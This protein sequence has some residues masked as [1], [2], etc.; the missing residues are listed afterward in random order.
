MSDIWRLIRLTAPRKGWM[1]AGLGLATLT[2]LAN[3]G[4]LALSGWFLAATAA[5]GLAGYAAQNAF[6]FF[7]PSAMV[8]FFATLRV[9]SRY[10]ERLVTH[11]ATFRLLADLRVW[12]YTRLEPLAPAALQGQRSADLLGRIVSDIDTLNLFYL[13]VF[14][15]VLTALAAALLMASFF[16]FFSVPAAL[17]LILGLG[18]NGALAPVLTARL[19]A[20]PG[21]AITRL[22]SGLR[23]EY[24]EALQ[25][26]GE[27]LVS[28]AAPAMQA[29][30]AA[31][32]EEL[33]A[34]QARLGG[35]AALGASLSGLA[36]NATLLAVLVFG[37]RRFEAGG[38]GAAQV[39]M[40]LL[41]A[42]AAF[43]ATA[44]L[45]GALNYLG[46]IKTAARRIFALADQMPPISP[47]ATAAP[48]LQRYDLEL[49]GVDLAYDGGRKVL[50]GFS[51]SLPQGRHVGIVGVSGSGKSTLINLLLR[52]HEYQAGTARLGGVDLRAFSSAQMARH[53]TIISQR[54]H[55]FH[56]SIRDNLLLANGA[57]DEAALWHA[58]EVAQLA[59]FVRG[60]AQG[61]DHLVGEGGASLSGGQ[62]R[63]IA[64]ARAVLKPAPLLIL[65][66]PTEGLDVETERAFLADLAPLLAGRSVLYITHR[67]AGLA[68]MDEVY[69]LRDGKA[70]RQR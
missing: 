26:M 19:G 61:L 15:P 35:V 28:G 64:L 37:A 14:V 30:A 58:L 5:A 65:D 53:A 55:L 20:G 43:E 32:N 66:E 38:L 1:L 12:F 3:F 68:L 44:P 4:L 34:A 17:A 48:A 49:A 47:P 13:R 21:A 22:N 40:L 39:P 62:A 63:R 31:L 56:T 42:M 23:A 9:G 33:A 29:R 18:L 24:V 45:P 16:A 50:D 46:Q 57:A 25:G 8:R 54:S 70:V 7:T 27:L 10:A 6:N 36:A 41:G 59:D 69:E 60:L 2:L 51:L 11:E 67:P 52:F